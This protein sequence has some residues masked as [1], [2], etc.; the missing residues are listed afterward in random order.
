M[1]RVPLAANRFLAMMSELT[2][3]WLLL[4]AATIALERQ[5]GLS[6][7]DPDRAFYEGKRHAAAYFAEN[8]LP[9]VTAA[10]QVLG[11]GNRSA[12]DIPDAAFATT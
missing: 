10:A 1:D 9:D 5:A 2:L 4:D 11:T 8:V 6:A 7:D 12:L 3:G